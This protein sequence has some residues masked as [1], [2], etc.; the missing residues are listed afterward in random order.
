MNKKDGRHSHDDE[1]EDVLDK[2][3]N[4]IE[5][6]HPILSIIFKIFA[7]IYLVITV[8]FFVAVMKLN[9][10][11]G[12][13]VT[14]FSVIEALLTIALI[15]GLAKLHTKLVLNIISL[16]LVIAI[17]S[18]YFVGMR[19]IGATT[20]FLKSAFQEVSETEEYF[21]VVR[22]ESIYEGVEDLNNI[23]TYAFQIEEKTKQDV[24]SKINKELKSSD[25][26][27]QMGNDLLSEKI[28]SILVSSSQYD[29]LSETIE[30][31][32]ES[33]RIL[34]ITVLNIGQAN[35]IEDDNSQFKTQNGVFNVYISGIDTSGTI[36]KVSRSDA[37]IV[38]T[39]NTNTHEVLLTS[40]P[41]DYYVTLHSK[42]A[43]DKLTHSGIY[44]INETVTTVEDLLG[45]EINYYVR[46]NFTTLIKLVDT[47]GGIDVNSEYSFKTQGYQFNEGMNHL[48]GA[49]ALAF[50]RERHSF[51]SG[52]NQR[53]RDQQIVIDAIMNKVLNSTTL[54]T[55]YADILNNL[56]GCFQ[57]NVDQN[58]INELV[59]Q[60]LR[61]MPKWTTK[62]Y[63]L[64]GTGAR[65]STYSMGSQKLY[66][67]IPNETSV[68]EAKANIKSTME[69]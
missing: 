18:V 49:Q 21:I 42:G 22:K 62:S 43:K 10:L 36:S 5:K 68:S 11:P 64:Y 7:L 35:Q 3:E 23:D 63:Q 60:Q 19:Y 26:L 1:L 31:F 54:L 52:D 58:D 27:T 65:S 66:V 28:E 51:A 16:L 15:F 14:L 17:S 30:N 57:T 56:E 33:T 44:G 8:I 40:I 53:V 45:I 37:N 32:E 20:N 12:L 34:Y 41:R 67:M 39:V 46:V 24:F 47:L 9:M 69:K 2:K 25:D 50:S 38:A 59:K 61:T 6:K 48:N 4:G 55:K 29:M 13:Y